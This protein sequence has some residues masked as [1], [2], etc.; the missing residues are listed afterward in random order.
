M[1]RKMCDFVTY[2]DFAHRHVALLVFARQYGFRKL[3]TDP[4]LTQDVDPRT[5]A[6]IRFYHDKFQKDKPELL[7]HIR[8]ATKTDQQ[9][10]DDLDYLKQEISKLHEAN[11]DLKQD[12]DQRMAELSYECNR[13]VTALNADYDKLYSLVQT[14]ISS[15]SSSSSGATTAAANGNGIQ[16]HQQPVA[17]VAVAAPAPP[18]PPAAPST[19]PNHSHDATAVALAA[20]R[21]LPNSR[22]TVMPDL[23]HSLSHAAT[24]GLQHIVHHPANN[25]ASSAP[26][27]SSYHPQQQQHSIAPSPAGHNNARHINNNNIVQ[28]VTDSS[29]SSGY[30][31]AN[32]KQEHVL[33]V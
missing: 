6:Y 5:S 11:A 24:V 15:S 10:R 22:R 32:S 16:H 2:D 8:R 17:A 18:P 29:S 7:Q 14:F 23:L 3:R 9:S 27:S 33:E 26:A 21:D 12:F 25:E 4:I 13:R 30:S 31:T 1:I 20:L 28:V 19:L